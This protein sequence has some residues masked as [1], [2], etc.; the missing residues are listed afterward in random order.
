MQVDHRTITQDTHPA[1][2]LASVATDVRDVMTGYA[3]MIDRAEADLHPFLQRLYA[4]H[5]AHARELLEELQRHGGHARDTG[6][7]M[8]TVHTAIAA[9]RDWVGALDA[10]AL[11]QIVAGEDAIIASYDKALDALQTDPGPRSM[12]DR[13]RA[14]LSAHVDALRQ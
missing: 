1:E 5:D 14:A 3:A 4:L 2:V 13:H 12:L 8:A 9:I 11:P 6:S 7:Y 10:S